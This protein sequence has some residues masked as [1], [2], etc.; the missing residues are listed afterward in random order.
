MYCQNPSDSIILNGTLKNSSNTYR[1]GVIHKLGRQGRGR[2][3]SWG[4]AKCLLQYIILFSKTVYEGGGGQ[5]STKFCLHSLL[6]T[7]M[8]KKK[9][10][11]KI[12]EN[13][14]FIFN[15]YYKPLFQYSSD[16]YT[17]IST[18]LCIMDLIFRFQ[19]PSLLFE[20]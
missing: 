14:A 9:G 5:I 7:T 20:F 12:M 17:Y 6:M 2:A 10:W 16:K 3:N 1:Y 19:A 15:Y 11:P 8:S 4:F 13:F 18:Y